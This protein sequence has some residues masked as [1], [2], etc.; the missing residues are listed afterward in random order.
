MSKT[1]LEKYSIASKLF[2]KQKSTSVKMESAYIKKESTFP[3]VKIAII[4]SLLVIPC[5]ASSHY[6]QVWTTACRRKK[7]RFLS[8]KVRS[9]EASCKSGKMLRASSRNVM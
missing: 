7:S 3:D 5:H 6:G 9:L 2:I 8:R 1:V 4:S